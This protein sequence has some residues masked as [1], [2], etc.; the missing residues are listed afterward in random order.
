VVT[1]GL[2]ASGTYTL[3]V[4]VHG[5]AARTDGLPV[6]SFRC[7]HMLYALARGKSEWMGAVFSSVSRP[8]DATMRQ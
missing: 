7:L 1:P 2:L 8:F 5:G 4:S 3:H 6:H